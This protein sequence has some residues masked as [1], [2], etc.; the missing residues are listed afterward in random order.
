MQC[1]CGSDQTFEN[2]CSRFL[3]GEKSPTTAE[4]LMRSRYVAYVK[5]D[6]AYLKTTLAPEALKKFDEAATKKWVE[7]ADFKKLKILNTERGG[8]FDEEGVVEFLA[9]FSEGGQTYDHHEV[10]EFRK[11]KEGTWLFVDGHGH[12]HK[13]GEDPHQ[14]HHHHH[15]RV[16]TFV[17]QA[18]KVGRNDPCS[19]GS[20]KKFKK[21]C[22]QA[23]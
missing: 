5:G 6:T 4:A 23:N 16:E 10:S 17:R 22:G 9:T 1:P 3:S 14:H 8:P 15:H 7:T 11:N 20:G 21:C 13:E 12:R 18:P 19:C 2:C